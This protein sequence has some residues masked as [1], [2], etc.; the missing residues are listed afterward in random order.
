MSIWG[1]KDVT[2]KGVAS[3]ANCTELVELVLHKCHRITEGAKVRMA[4]HCDKVS[5]GNT[6]VRL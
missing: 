6:V 1:C 5:E 2:D 4:A 3:L